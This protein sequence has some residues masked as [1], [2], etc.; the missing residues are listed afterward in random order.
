MTSS[1]RSTK[2][3]SRD[4]DLVQLEASR[5]GELAC[6]SALVVSGQRELAGE[7]GKRRAVLSAAS[8]ATMLESRPPLR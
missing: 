3:A 4:L 6:V 8:A 5:R 2:S 1:I 7:P